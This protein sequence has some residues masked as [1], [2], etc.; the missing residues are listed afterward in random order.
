MSK[1]RHLLAAALVCLVP[2]AAAAQSGQVGSITGYV[3][4]EGGMPLRGIKISASSPTQIGGART[5]YSND[6]GSFRILQLAPGR[7]EVRASAPKLE[8]IIHKDI[9]VGISSA[10]EMNIVMRVQTKTEEIAVVEKAPLVVTTK[11]NV[12]E[13]FDLAMVES[14]PHGSRD[15]IHNQMVN[16]VA[17]GMNNRVRGGNTAQTIFSQD[18]FE[19]RGQFPTLKSSAAYE[20]NTGGFA[21]DNPMA[22]GGTINLVTKSGSNKFEFEFN[23]TLENVNRMRFFTDE[24]D[25]RSNRY[26]AVINPMVSGPIIKDK[27][28]YMF[29]TET[30]LIKEARDPDPE[31]IFLGTPESYE[32]FIQKGTLKL[33]WQVTSRNKVHSLTNFDSPHEWKMRGGVGIAP[34]AQ[35]NR[36]AFR[37]MQGL[38]WESLLSDSL[39]FRSQVGAIYIPQHFYPRLCETDPAHC[40]HIPRVVQKLPRTQEYGNNDQHRRED[41]YSIQTQN[42]LEYFLDGV[43]GDHAIQL[44]NNFYAESQT[45]RLS[46][47]GDRLYELLGTVP[48][49]KTTYFSNDPRIDNAKFGWWIG[50]STATRHTLTLSDA[51]RPTR[52]LTVTPAVSHVFARGTNNAGSTVINAAAF[53]PAVSVAWDAT[54]DGRTVLRASYNN[55]VD[56]NI[57]DLA[58][59]TLGGQVAQRC[60]YNEG[61]GGTL[62]GDGEPFTKE[63]EYSGGASRTTIG[64]PCGPTGYDATGRR[65]NTPLGIPRVYEY[66]LGAEREITPGIAM[67][68]DFVLKDFQNQ[69][70]TRETNR[71]WNG[72]GNG[73][74]PTGGYRNGRNET[75][76]DLGTPEGAG[77]TYKGATL[78]LN[79]RE[80][81]F[82]AKVAYTLS[83]L[84]GSVFEGINNQWGDIEPQ[85]VFLWGPLPDDHLHETKLQATYQVTPWLSTGLRYRYNSGVPFS[86][87]YRNPL[88]GDY[89][90]YNA[91]VGSDGGANRNDP[92]DDR[93]LRRPDIHDFNAQF[94][95]NMMPLTGQQLDFYVDVLNLLALRTPTNI[96][97]EDGRNF[98]QVTGRMEPFR[99]R[100]GLNY[101]Y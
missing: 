73:L 91:T 23:S 54:H 76:S 98:G 74:Q 80:G 29:N 100:L 90:Y 94:R 81:R 41:Q 64:L 49:Q 68:L 14:L 47:P 28:W 65:C 93:A 15:N 4:D 66:T 42:R 58:R 46:R 24:G 26:F 9:E 82:K 2:A 71:I 50:T 13:T 11:A 51:W 95:V 86:R 55:Y 52:Y 69:Y 37:L 48:E 75:V 88:T 20:V 77:R 67:A 5:A 96:G 62:D 32:K 7:F 101:K 22:S 6:E 43:G 1:A 87:L 61:G 60:K 72:S 27:L 35:Q 38:I 39:V 57:F 25:N 34:E 85:D 18:G 53:A 63:C 30:H 16:D 40:D 59:T 99:V 56:I 97:Q 10:T 31:G 21:V 79:K 92:A 19:M 17:G 36:H 33:T 84:R 78:A 70:E 3:F 8:T 12:K 89:N 45:V 83:Q 44:K